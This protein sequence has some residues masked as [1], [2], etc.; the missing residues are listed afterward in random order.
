MSGGGET[1]EASPIAI[2]GFI[3]L[4][5]SSAFI[6]LNSVATLFAT[7]RSLDPG[8]IS[9]LIFIQ[10]YHKIYFILLYNLLYV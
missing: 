3:A 4:S 2:D 5:G 1:D 8:L 9:E 6:T 10:L 7:L